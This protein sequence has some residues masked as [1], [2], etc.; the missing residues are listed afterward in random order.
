M[1]WE[2]TVCPAFIPHCRQSALLA[3][4]R[5]LTSSHLRTFVCKSEQTG[6][7]LQWETVSSSKPANAFLGSTGTKLDRRNVSQTGGCH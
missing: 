3:A 6:N 1:S 7:E 5:C 4:T 2:K